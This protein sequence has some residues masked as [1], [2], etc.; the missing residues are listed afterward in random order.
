MARI[1]KR[2]QQKHAKNRS[3]MNME[4]GLLRILRTNLSA[5][6]N[7][8]IKPNES[9]HKNIETLSIFGLIVGLIFQLYF[10]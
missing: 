7:G 5:M 3:K 4:L 9:K 10:V 1:T 2:I 8:E 6:K